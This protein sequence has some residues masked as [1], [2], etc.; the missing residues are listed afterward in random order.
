MVKIKYEEYY[1]D[2]FRRNHEKTFSNLTDLEN[3][4][5]DQM[6][7]DYSKS[8]GMYFPTPEKSAR[9]H[10]EGPSRIEFTPKL[11]GPTFWIRQIENYGGI[12]FSDGTFTSRKKHWSK[13][14][15]EWLKHCDM[16]QHSPKFSFV[17]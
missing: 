15:Q 7:Q 8:H 17:E 13:E 4:M 14:I 9:F 1:N 2:Y 5:F 6:Q 3:W 12:I 16:R 11:G 10:S